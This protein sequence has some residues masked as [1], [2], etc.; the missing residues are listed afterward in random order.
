MNQKDKIIPFDRFIWRS[1]EF[2]SHKNSTSEKQ[3]WSH[4]QEAVTLGVTAC[5]WLVMSQ[6]LADSWLLRA[7]TQADESD[8]LPVKSGRPITLLIYGA[9]NYL[10]N[11]SATVWHLADLPLVTRVSE[12]PATSIYSGSFYPGFEYFISYIQYWIF[13]L[14]VKVSGSSRNVGYIHVA[15]LWQKSKSSLAWT[16]RIS[17]T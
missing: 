14:K 4:N 13:S 6:H 12:K 5:H 10:L 11:Y 17:R 7:L 16:F 3:S 2:L 8:A 1:L 9:F 15:T